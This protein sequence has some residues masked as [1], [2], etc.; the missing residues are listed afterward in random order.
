MEFTNTPPHLSQKQLEAKATRLRQR[1]ERTTKDLADDK[2]E[3]TAT[4]AAI[5]AAKT[6][7]KATAT[8]STKVKAKPATCNA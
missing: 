1:I 7:A 3:L 8:T 6:A 5:K 2:T 4:L